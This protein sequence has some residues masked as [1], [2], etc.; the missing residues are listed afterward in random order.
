MPGLGEFELLVL[1]SILRNRDRPFANRVREEL[2]T[3]GERP[4]TRGALYRS[5]D[6]L[7]EKGCISWELEPSAVP[8]RG[9]HPMRRLAVTPKGEAAV[10]AS[11][12]ILFRFFDGIV[13][14]T[15]R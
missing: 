9:G 7:R 10:R 13:S 6:R 11:G 4:V 8:E 5:L 12:R 15:K 14:P 3:L 2:E 1:L